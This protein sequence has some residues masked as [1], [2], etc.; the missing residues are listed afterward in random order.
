MDISMM[1][2]LMYLG[3][4]GSPFDTPHRLAALLKHCCWQQWGPSPPKLSRDQP[5]A[6]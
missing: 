5:Y 4:A 3:R 2:Y 1:M 6:L